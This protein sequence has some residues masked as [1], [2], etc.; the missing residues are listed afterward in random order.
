MQFVVAVA[1]PVRSILCGVKKNRLVERLAPLSLTPNR[2]PHT[3]ASIR[4]RQKGRLTPR[5]RG[6]TQ[7]L[8]KDG[9]H[10]RG[11]RNGR[12]R[13]SKTPSKLAE[14]WGREGLDKSSKSGWNNK[15]GRGASS[16]DHPT[17]SNES[18]TN[19]AR[20]S[21]QS[22][23]TPSAS[24]TNLRN[25]QDTRTKCKRDTDEIRQGR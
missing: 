25:L 16:T 5:Q 4:Q 2:S 3:D 20:I 9:A 12:N 6:G 14:G 11:G 17:H 13:K 21:A 22:R 7:N 24:H 1:K 18:R 10:F 23:P 15:G 8:T 19:L